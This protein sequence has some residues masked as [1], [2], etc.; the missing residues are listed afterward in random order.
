MNAGEIYTGR[1]CPGSECDL[2]T[3][4]INLTKLVPFEILNY[5]YTHNTQFGYLE[6]A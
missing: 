4:R 5:L 6:K 2:T 1:E 3:L